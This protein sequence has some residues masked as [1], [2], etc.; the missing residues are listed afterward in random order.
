MSE[1]PSLR[2]RRSIVYPTYSTSVTVHVGLC[3]FTMAIE[4]YP[5]H[6]P[7]VEIQ[8]TFY[9]PPRN[10]L[11]RGWIAKVPASLEFTMKVWQ[12]V[13]HAANSPTYR[14]M[15][16]PLPPGAGPG[17]FRDSPAVWDGWRRSVECA[18]VLGAT[19]MLFQCPA[20]FVPTDEN[21]GRMRRF[22]ETI[23]R[24]SARLLWE[25]RGPAWVKKRSLALSLCRDLDLVHVVDPLVTEPEPGHPIYWRLHG[26]GGPR[27]SYTDAELQR[28]ADVLRRVSSDTP[29]YVMFNNLPRVGDAKRFARSSPVSS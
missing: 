3:G 27:H 1:R 23:E 10:D 17:F 4:D 12:L 28:L 16:A 11:M 19:A 2:R 8:H 7:V 22:F 25:P 15:K 6:F 5:L 13:T 14:K 21:V 9:E 26:I 24:P 18:Q 20:S 29:A